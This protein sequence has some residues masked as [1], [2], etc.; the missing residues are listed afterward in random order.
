M[1]TTRGPT[2]R[3]LAMP[4]VAAA[5]DDAAAAAGGASTT[6]PAGSEAAA[7]VEMAATAAAAASAGG[8]ALDALAAADAAPAAGGGCSVECR[9]VVRLDGATLL[10]GSVAPA[11]P[12]VADMAA[13]VHLAVKS[14]AK[15]DRSQLHST[16]GGALQLAGQQREGASCS[17]EMQPARAQ[18][19]AEPHHA[20]QHRQSRRTQ[21]AHPARRL[22]NSR[23][24]A[25]KR[26]NENACPFG[27][28]R[29]KAR[30]GVRTNEFKQDY[31]YRRIV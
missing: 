20:Q 13:A 8:A 27:R 4:A 30:D 1:S 22:T 31:T 5:A 28:S 15:V 24:V 26:E 18:W 11:T 16:V 7:G 23:R 2:L 17:S 29:R 10:E 14:P 19:P 25:A 21:A 9:G 3:V 12:S 6:S